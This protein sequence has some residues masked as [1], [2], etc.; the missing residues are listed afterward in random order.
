MIAKMEKVFVA[1]SPGQK[2]RLLDAMRELG[3]LHIV[4]VEPHRARA[5]DK[6]LFAIGQL[7]RAIQIASDV[8]PSASRPAAIDPMDACR[9]ILGI[10]Q[11]STEQIVRLGQLAR[12]AQQAEIWDDTRTGQLDS[13]RKAGLDVRFLIGPADA[14]GRIEAQCVHII[15]RIGR[16][17]VLLATVDKLAGQADPQKP[18]QAQQRQ[19]LPDGFKEL[20]PPAHD[21]P[22]LLAEASQIQEDQRRGALRLAE[23]AWLKSD[24]QAHLNRLRSDAD[25]AKAH[26]SG[27]DDEKIFAIQGWALCGL[28]GRLQD[29]L[30]RAGLVAAVHTLEPGPDEEPPTLLRPPRWARPIVGLLNLLGITPGYREHDVTGA[31]MLALPIFAAMLIGDGGYGLLFILLPAVFYRGMARRIGSH[32]TQLLIVFGLTTLV[33]G[34]ITFSYFGMSQ[35]DL[36]GA[37]GIWAQAAGFLAQFKLLSVDFDRQSQQTLQRLC[38]LIG[39]IHLSAAHLWRARVSFPDPRCLG[40][41]GWA[42]FLWGMYG[43]VNMLVLKDPFGWGTPYPYLMIFGA[44]I[45]VIFARSGRPTIK[46]VLIDGLALQILPTIGALSDTISYVRLMAIGL[47]GAVMATTFN[48]MAKGV[49]FIPAV[50]IILIVGH[51]FNIALCMLAL[52]AHGVRLNVL[53]FSNN[54]GMQWNGYPYEPFARQS[55]DAK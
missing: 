49:A 4:P 14:V 44:A 35:Q 41:V 32:M 2:D 12:Q 20:A 50:V 22:S 27:M 43:L 5:D 24:M 19:N 47:A 33:W 31:F 26:R 34:V 51:A 53:E 13:L 29:D 28:A 54:L 17:T 8:K 30:R 36:A 48:N 11:Q 21:R 42:V 25:W 40:N 3:V 7:G 39:A 46:G 10:Q 38:F 45:M 55:K 37:G 1:A 52:L 23:L 9:E 6:T 15:R 18:Q 16:K